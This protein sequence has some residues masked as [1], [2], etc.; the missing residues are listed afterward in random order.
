METKKQTKEETPKRDSQIEIF[1]K[2]EYTLQV[3]CLTVMSGNDTILSAKNGRKARAL[4]PH[5][6]YE[7][8]C[9]CLFSDTN[10]GKSIFAVQIGCHIAQ[11]G[12]IVAY[13]DFELSQNQFSQRYSDEDGEFVFP[14]TF[15]RVEIDPE[16]MSPDTDI[17]KDIETAALTIG[18]GVL[19]IDNL[20][21]LVMDSENA[22]AANGL[23]KGI[24]SLQKRFGWT[25]IV[26]A[27]TPKRP[28]G[29]PLSLN[30]LAGSRQIANFFDSI[31]AL[32]R[33]LTKDNVR[34]VKQLKVRTEALCYTKNSVLTFVIERA[35]HMLRMTDTGF[36]TEY[37]M[38]KSDSAIEQE[39]FCRMVE[40]MLS[41]GMTV[42]DIAAETGE[43]QQ[44]IQKIVRQRMS[45]GKKKGSSP[46]SLPQT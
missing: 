10:V 34:Y 39:K 13:F 29:V 1:E 6:V 23:M 40:D 15:F 11:K 9:C 18:A 27:H 12:Q 42:K 24:K 20:S 22:E 41:E 17:I 2:N 5:L 38:L 4:F 21:W 46:K 43:T 3:G 30:D 44:K 32:G 25:I 28:E 33:C 8:E 19:I 31:F 14:E 36:S 7:G 35:D 45:N 16:H 26:V 37:Q